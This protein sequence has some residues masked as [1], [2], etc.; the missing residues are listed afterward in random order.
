MASALTLSA[1][2]AEGAFGVIGSSRMS[3]EGIASRDVA[4]RGFAALCAGSVAR[5]VV[6]ATR[7]NVELGL[8]VDAWA[9]DITRTTQAAKAKY[10]DLMR[11]RVGTT[12]AALY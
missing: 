2:P 5:V 8:P 11:R 10:T 12:A 4:G 9:S 3:R 6:S 1:A 7:C